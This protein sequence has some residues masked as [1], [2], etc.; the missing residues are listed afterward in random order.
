VPSIPVVSQP[1]FIAESSMVSQVAGIFRGH[2]CVRSHLRAV[3]GATE[4]YAPFVS[5]QLPCSLILGCSLE[6][7]DLLGLCIES[8]QARVARRSAQVVF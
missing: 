8:L 7:I 6:L 1:R 5:C 4:V 3:R 2:A